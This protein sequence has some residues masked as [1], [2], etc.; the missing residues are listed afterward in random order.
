MKPF[1]MS[2]VLS[3][4]V[5]LVTG[6]NAGIGAATAVALARQGAAV[7]VTYLRLNKVP[8]PAVPETYRTSRARDATAVMETI[9]A[10]G[11]RAVAVEADL[12]D[13]AVPA[14]LFDAAEEQLGP[15]DILINN[16]S[17]WR[18][19]T[20]SAAR[21]DMH[22]RAMQPVTADTFDANFAVGGN[23]PHPALPLR[24]HRGDR[25]VLGAEPQAAR[26]IDAH[27]RGHV[28]L[29][30][31]QGAADTPVIAQALHR[32]RGSDMTPLPENAVLVFLSFAQDRLRDAPAN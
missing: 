6:A 29:V 8:D 27:A 5:A 28:A 11:G 20:F 16:A 23:R 17:G 12:A 25:G 13:A 1:V 18:Q 30:R 19:D 10:A 4:H 24:D 15:V 32:R 21:T 14:R 9:T 31:D 7:L 26:H 3:G 2:N 22:G